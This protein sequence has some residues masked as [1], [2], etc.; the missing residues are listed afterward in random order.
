MRLL[1]DRQI[2][3]ATVDQVFTVQKHRSII[4]SYVVDLLGTGFSDKGCHLPLIFTGRST[5]P[6]RKRKG[7]NSEEPK[8][9]AREGA[10][11]LFVCVFVHG[12]RKP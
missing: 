6:T 12:L 1:H 10:E 4:R 2:V 9:R 7:G 11:D 3:N 8:K 5:P